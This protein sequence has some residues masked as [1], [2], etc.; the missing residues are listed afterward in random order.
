MAIKVKYF[1]NP[2]Y[3]EN[4]WGNLDPVLKKGQ[5][6]VVMDIDNITVRGFKIGD[7]V[8]KWTLLPLQNEDIYI[9]DDLVTNE[10]G[11]VKVGDSLEGE[12]VVDII[13]RMVSP[14]VNPTITNATNDADGVLKNAAIVEVGNSVDTSVNLNYN[15]LA[16]ENLKETNNIF[17]VDLSSIFDNSGLHTHTGSPINLTLKASLAP[18]SPTKYTIGVYGLIEGG[19]VTATANTTI[20]FYSTV[21]WGYDTNADLYPDGGS[22][23]NSLP[24]EN[25]LVAASYKATYSFVGTKYAYMLVPVDMI[26]AGVSIIFEEVTNTN[27]PSNYSML[28][29]GT[30]TINNGSAT[31]D[32][33][34]YRS[35]FEII[36]NTKM[37]LS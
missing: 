23:N 29:M 9:Y 11:D 4:D 7:G 15:A 30:V 34:V 2:S 24:T 17:V 19:G 14:F 27:Q 16:S 1:Y 37:K 25:R 32:Y 33:V 5:M 35:E 28:E 20:N 8:N 21:L 26:T 36:V 13:R 6:G 10:I 31:Y 3:T 22:Y 12:K 18:T